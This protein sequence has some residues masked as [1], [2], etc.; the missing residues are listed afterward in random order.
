MNESTVIDPQNTE[1][2]EESD[3]QTQEAA[4]AAV[5]DTAQANSEFSGE[6]GCE[7]KA[8]ETD[9]WNVR[10]PDD[11][12]ADPDPGSDTAA[13]TNEADGLDELRGE[14]KI[15]KDA[16]AA[17]AAQLERAEREYGEFSSLYPSISLSDLPDGVWRDVES[18]IPLAAAYALSERRR[19]MLQRSAE[20]SNRQNTERS[21]GGVSG[22]PVDYF[23]P[24]EVNK[25]SRADVRSHFSAILE[26]MKTWKN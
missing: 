10:M 16:F 26:S 24:D 9:A 6:G 7:T 22:V 15:L 1:M 25:M 20:Q 8:D 14:L 21:A 2:A 23:S 3:T 19:E 18:G 12:N 5:S 17:R 11:P 13:H 4:E